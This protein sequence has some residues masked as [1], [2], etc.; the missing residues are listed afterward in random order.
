MKILLT[1]LLF[2]NFRLSNS[3]NFID[4]IIAIVDYAY[5]PDALKNDLEIV[6]EYFNQLKNN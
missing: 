1:I 6:A 4:G 3:Q 5:T 2:L